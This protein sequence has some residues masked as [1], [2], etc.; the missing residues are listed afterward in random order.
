M[1]EVWKKYRVGDML[2]V[3]LRDTEI[4]RIGFTM[5]PANLEP[6]LTCK[7]EDAP[8]SFVQVK[9]T[10][11][12]IAGNFSNGRSMRRSESSQTLRLENHYQE[13]LDDE[14]R[15]I[16]V[17]KN[18]KIKAEHILT[19]RKTEPA[20]RLWVNVQNTTSEPVDVEMLGSFSA[21]PLFPLKK[22]NGIGDY[23]LYR[24]RS[25]W[26]EEG[27]LEKTNLLDLQM[28]PSWQRTG[29]QNVRFGQVGTMPVREFFPWMAVEDTANQCVMG[30]MI[31]WSGSWQMELFS[32]DGLPAISGGLADR[33]FGHWMKQLA[34]GEVLQTPWAILTVCKG[35]LDDLCNRMIDA[36]RRNIRAAEELPIIFN[37][38][39][40][41]WGNPSAENLHRIVEKLQGKHV[42]YCVIDAGWYADE[43]LNWETNMGD[44][45]PNKK[46]FPEG[47]KK[48][49]DDIRAHGMIPGIWF[50]MENAGPKSQIYQKT[51]YLLTRDGYP[52]TT[53]RR[54][55]LDLRKKEVM[56]YLEQKV[57]RF[58]K[59]QGF[60]YIK[61]DYNDNIGIG[62][63]GDRSLGEGLRKQVLASHA[64]FANIR[65]ECPDIVIEN[66]ASGGHRLDPAMLALTE[67]SSISDAHEC[68]SIPKIA[69]NVLRAVPAAQSQIWAV[70]RK[71]DDEKRLFYTMANTFLGRMCLS[72]DVTELEEW[73]WKIVDSGIQFYRE[74]APIIKNGK[75]AWYGKTGAAYAHLT[76][77][78]AVTFTYD[79][80]ILLIVHTFYDHPAT[81]QLEMNDADI[82]KN[83]KDF[84]DGKE[85]Q[86][87]KVYASEHVSVNHLSV[88]HMSVEHV[89]VN[90]IS[91]KISKKIL[92][93]GMEELEAAVVLL[94]VMKK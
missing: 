71:T 35:T 17:L 90:P 48:V 39:C 74:C 76:G 38:F 77:W 2:C 28:E 10:S 53:E 18:E 26:S 87:K 66:C 54:R 86:I 78:Q 33:E 62:C 72:G 92:L 5:I 79:D 37:E 16:T 32:E 88:K 75:I 30:A 85:F 83:T 52:I 4:D 31:G 44:W 14:T 23:Q 84:E 27:R 93:E 9:L 89:S 24:L 57:I 73:Q 3:Y 34:P 81:V 61:V 1:K 13:I 22:R 82:V 43:E 6:E 49:A 41:T 29:M 46:L 36:Q 47:I 19:F 91:E 58:L 68:I 42:R 20:V 45:V 65:K 55:F 94:E 69:A 40:T 11:D 50:E 80:K 12:R 21:A 64:L 59:E 25:R 7:E 8:E 63:D 60:G 15:I 51:E 67:M 56:S 70:L